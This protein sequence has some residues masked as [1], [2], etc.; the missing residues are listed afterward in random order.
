MSAAKFLFAGTPE[1]ALASLR[2]L[3]EN[4]YVPQVVL[5]QPD[6]PA[7]RGKKLTASPVKKFAVDN[8]IP[9]WQPGTLKASDITEKIAGLQPD[10]MVVAAYG[11][12]LPPAMLATPRMGC[13]NVHASLLP[14]WRGAAPIQHAILN[15]DYET[16]ISLMQMEAGLDTGPVFVTAATPIGEQENAGELH[17]RLAILGGEL[18]VTHFDKIAAGGLQA[19]PQDDALAT[20]AGKINKA[21]A[22][23]LWHEAAAEI[24]RKIRAYNPVPGAAFELD[25]EV[26]KCF[27]AETVG[28]DPLSRNDDASVG[29]VVAAGKEGIDVVCGTGIL[30]MT[31][32]QRPGRRRINA[33]EFAAQTNPLGK[34]LG[35]RW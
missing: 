23:I 32:L 24:S 16:G 29:S 9:V 33:A 28:A 34:R 14:R 10:L 26:V 6:R 13:I 2:A 18:L 19:L 27:V 11:L 3:T 7:G 35:M 31:Q 12:I 25:D 8:A 30:R 15:G 17:D 22:L 21:D 4:G 20:Y 5:T 1:F